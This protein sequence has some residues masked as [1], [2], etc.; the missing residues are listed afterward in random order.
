MQVGSQSKRPALHL[1]PLAGRGRIASAIRVRGS[2]RKRG[3]DHFKN[4]RRVEQDIVIPESQDAVVTFGKPFVADGV[5]LAVGMLTAVNLDDETAF[6]ANE[7]DNIGTN[8]FLPN[9]F[10]AAQTARSQSIPQR[11]FGICRGPTQVPG[12]PCLCLSCTAQAETPPHPDCCAIRP[13]PA[14][15]ERLQFA[16]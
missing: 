12:A 1:A 2:F 3:G 15:G 4:P 9:E 6:S 13:L 16:P 14:R 11:A 5:A 8:R 7:I 10:V